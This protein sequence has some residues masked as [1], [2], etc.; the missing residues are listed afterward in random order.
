MGRSKGCFQILWERG[1]IDLNKEYSMDGIKDEEGEI[2]KS[3]SLNYLM[4][5]CFDFV[6]EKTMLQ[7][8]G[9]GL[10]CII[11]RSPKCT[12]EVAGDGIEYD[13]AMAKL[14]YRKQDLNKKKGKQKFAELVKRAVS[15][16]VITMERTRAF[17][18]RARLNLLSYHLLE[19]DGKSATPLDV[20]K[21]KK[22]QKTHRNIVDEDC[23]FVAKLL[24]KASS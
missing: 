16:E 4:S 19:K 10:G 7:H 21:F 15:S 12:P 8:V 6:N 20:K 23:G 22:E 9:E 5:Q 13:W 1:F 18:R 14:W 17:S 3:T 11:D 2:D 24:R